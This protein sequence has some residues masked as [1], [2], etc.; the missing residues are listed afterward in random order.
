MR[1]K[2]S[3]ISSAF[4]TKRA[5]RIQFIGAFDTLSDVSGSSVFDISFN[6]SIY[7]FRHAVAMHEDRK[8]LAP[9]CLFPPEL[10]QSSLSDSGRSF[11]QAHFIGNHADIGGAARKSGLALYPLQWMLIQAKDL[12]LVVDPQ[13]GVFSPLSLV[14]PGSSIK[15]P[16]EQLWTFKA[17]N[18]IATQMQ[19]FREVHGLSR[20]HEKSYAIKLQSSRLSSLRQKQPRNPFTSDGFLRGYCA[21]APQGTIIHP[22]VYLLLDL[23][24]NV[25]LENKELKLQRWVEAWRDRML[26]TEAGQGADFWDDNDD[27]SE[28]LG[29]LRVLVCGN[30]GGQYPDAPIATPAYAKCSQWA[31]PP[32]STRLLE[33]P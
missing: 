25:V 24:I 10:H 15:K 13:G 21:G 2:V 32:S 20:N 14:L 29:A 16:P 17:A 31:N 27:D 18:D 23:H 8:T 3:S 12:G 28:S 30:T 19:D 11:I 1:C 6:S 7:H 22:S 26:G 4:Q 5:P 9:E 33:S